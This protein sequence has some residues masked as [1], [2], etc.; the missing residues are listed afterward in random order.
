MREEDEDDMTRAAATSSSPLFFTC[1]NCMHA[2]TTATDVE[3]ERTEPRCH[4]TYS[5][6]TT[7]FA[8]ASK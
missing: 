3:R 5:R 7:L 6:V 2:T 1:G 8:A 4:I